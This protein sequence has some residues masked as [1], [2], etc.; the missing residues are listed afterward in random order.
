MISTAPLGVG[1]AAH[2]PFSCPAG[3]A[4]VTASVGSGAGP[5][6]WAAAPTADVEEDGPVLDGGEPVFDSEESSP[7]PASSVPAAAAPT[8]SSISRRRA[9]RRV[10]NPSAQSATISLW[11]YCSKAIAVD[12]S[13]AAR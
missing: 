10:R 7:H 11:T 4:N 5:T 12:A 13:H 2:E 6:G 1:A 9:S 3:P 8:P